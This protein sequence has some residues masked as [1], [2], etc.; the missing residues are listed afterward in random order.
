VPLL[1]Y[2]VGVFEMR[3]YDRV[4][5]V[6]LERE[7]K[8]AARAHARE[9]RDLG[10]SYSD[11]RYSF[12]TG[13]YMFLKATAQERAEIQEEIDEGASYCSLSSSE[14]AGWDFAIEREV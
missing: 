10:M 7:M 5:S 11:E 2:N 4:I 6:K 9:A 1:L 8:Q 14:I 3:K 13:F 12:I